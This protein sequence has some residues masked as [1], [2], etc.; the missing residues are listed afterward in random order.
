MK[1]SD[2]ATIVTSMHEEFHRARLAIVT[3][4][5]GMQVNQI[6]Q[7]RKQLRGAQAQMHVVKNTLAV[8]SHGRDVARPHSIAF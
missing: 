8:A 4:C 2:K 3:E 6:T 1:K 7:L 5:S